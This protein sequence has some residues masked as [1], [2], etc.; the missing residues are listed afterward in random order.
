MLQVLKSLFSLG[1]EK[2]G[3]VNLVMARLCRL[4]SEP[5]GTE[6]ALHMVPTIVDA[7]MFGTVHKKPER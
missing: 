2:T 5:G 3:T 4:W 1:V 7:C 6:L